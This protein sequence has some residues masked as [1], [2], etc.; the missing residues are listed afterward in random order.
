TRPETMLGDTAIAV[1]P[2]DAKTRW[3]IGGRV[4]LPLTEITLPIVADHAVDPEFG[5]GFVKVTPAHDAS[6]FEI[7]TR[8]GLPMPTVM[9]PE[10]RMHDPKDPAG[11]RVPAAIEGKDRLTAREWVVQQL[12]KEGLLEKIEP[13]HHAVRRCYRCD[14]IVEPRLSDQWFVR[15]QPLATPVLEAYRAGKLRFVP[16]RWGGVYENWLANIRDWNISRQLWWGHRIPVFTCEACGET[17]ADRTDPMRCR[18]CGAAGIKQDP[19]VL[20]TWFSSWLW[21]FAT[22]GWPDKTPDL[23]RYYPGHTLVT[24]SE[25]IFFWVARMEM[26]GYHFMGRQPFQTVVINGTVRDNLHRRMSKSAGNGI[27]PLEV[28]RRYGADALRYTLIAGAPVGTD[29]VMDPNDLDTT[30]GAGRNFANKL[31]NAGRLILSGLDDA[32]PPLTRDAELELADRWILSR[33]QRAIEATTEAIARHRLSDAAGAVYHFVWDELADWY[34]E[35]VKP[36]LYGTAPGGEVAKAVL[37]TV[38]DTALRLLHPVMPFV[39]EQLWEHLPGERETLLAVAAWPEPDAA[40]LDEEAEARFAQVRS[41]VTAVRSVRAEYGVAPSRMVRAFV[42]PGNAAARDAFTAERGTIERLAKI[43]GLQLE[44]DRPTEAGAH[45]VLADGTDVFV[46]LGDAIDVRRE[47]DR[48]RG[49]LE[50][51][52]H[53]MRAV[54]AKLGNA[55][56]VSRA[57]AEVVARER[58]KAAALREQ[59]EV[60]ASKLH[61]LNCQ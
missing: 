2:D 55:Q 28:V 34:L 46:P 53:Q 45:A 29:L 61:A 8:H 6:D 12:R 11:R 59:R 40:W 19:D 33:C 47:C 4:R 50:R 44:G 37:V 36:R 27:D 30:F 3:A 16:E 24:A 54:A 15:M 41:L 13:H 14:T 56:F 52:D 38:L 17:W 7:G 26:A 25:I 5:T 9:D 35:Q 60:L 49:E 31:W 58:T 10:A 57:P 32:P 20:D 42:R 22:L 39:T 43:S 1:H 23:Q 48:L 51:L 21:P 18:A